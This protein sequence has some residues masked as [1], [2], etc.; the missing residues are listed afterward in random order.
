MKEL[1]SLENIIR[2]KKYYVSLN[3]IPQ[4]SIINRASQKINLAGVLWRQLFR[5]SPV[6]L[7]SLFQNSCSELP[8]AHASVILAL[9]YIELYDKY[10]LRRYYH[11]FLKY[12]NFLISKYR[13][14]KSEYFAIAQNK[15][16]HLT[17]YSTSKDDIAPLLTCYAGKC[18]LRAYE[19]TKE[20]LFKK[21]AE[22]VGHYFINEADKELLKENELY[23]NYVPGMKSIIY[24]SS[25]EISAFLI[26]LAQVIHYDEFY[27]TGINGLRFIVKNQNIDGSWFYGEKKAHRYI[28]NFHTTY[29]LISLFEALKFNNDDKI[30]KSLN[31]GLDFYETN[32]FKRIDKDVLRPVHFVSGEIPLNSNIIQKVDLR[33]AASSII[34]FSKMKKLR[35]Y[36]DIYAK[37]VLYWTFKNM[38]SGS[39][40]ANEITW[41]WKNNIRYIEFNSWMF[42]SLAIFVRQFENED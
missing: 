3:E 38:K 15:V 9:A 35:P 22:S 13:S 21:Y 12:F 5:I 11:E 6:D 41:F 27:N 10:R 1:E 37:E 2:K 39:E 28:D 7:R 17:S 20:P 30:I 32:L 33:D 8:G 23:F 36:Y 29:I 40:F 4:N 25:A 24:N 18:F 26:Q 16:I 34:L 42:F 19:I 31:A 14:S